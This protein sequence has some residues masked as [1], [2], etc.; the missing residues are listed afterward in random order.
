MLLIILIIICFC[1]WSRVWSFKYV[2]IWSLKLASKWSAISNNS[3]CKLVHYWLLMGRC[4]I[5]YSE[6]GTR[7]S[8]SPHRPLLAVPNV[9]A[10][11]STASV[12]ITVLLYNDPVLCGFNVAIKGLRSCLITKIQI[13]NTFLAG[14]R[15]YAYRNLQLLF[16][17]V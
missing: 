11:P 5:W 16:T 12:P 4:Y 10:H 2:W 15:Y 3:L 14:S 13:C 8:R 17:S 1:L 9:T 6:E 7:M